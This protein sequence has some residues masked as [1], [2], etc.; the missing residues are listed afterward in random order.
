MER[1]PGQLFSGTL[2]LLRPS[3]TATK[4]R[5]AAEK[6]RREAEERAAGIEPKAEDVR[7]EKRDERPKIVW[8]KPTDKRVPLIAIPTEQ[9]PSDFVENHNQ[10]AQQLFVACI[11]RWPITSLHPFGTLV[12]QIGEIG[13]IEVET[14]ALLKDNNVISEEFSENVMKCL[15]VTPWIIPEKEL[16][17]R[18]DLRT[19]RI[20]TI[21]PPASKDLDDA[22]SC[23][24]LPEGGYE[25]GVHIA[26]VCYFVKPNTA[27]DRDARKRATTVYLV[28]KPVPMLPPQ[29]SEEIC[30]LNPGADR[31]AFSVIWKM[32][33]DGKILESWFGRTVIR[34]CAKLA[35][36]HFQAVIEGQPLD[37]EVTIY[38]EIPASEIEADIKVFYDLSSRLRETRFKN[39]SLSMN[40]IKLNFQ[41]NENGDPIECSVY[42]KMKQT[43]W[44]RSSCCLRT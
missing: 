7:E 37:S 20:F 6:A 38:D 19:T 15:P 24:R 3:S 33:P 31:L 18:R 44:S 36:G 26:D 10:Y 27:L 28:Q 30:S 2:A 40:S 22:I 17:T 4:E 13:G 8:F 9:A 11:K 1:M 16:E 14:E 42:E 12:T 43:V 32:T 34:P 35:Y 23:T 41:L 5:E 39:G 21:D 25:I 29:L